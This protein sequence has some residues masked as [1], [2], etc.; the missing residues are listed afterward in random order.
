MFICASTECFPELGPKEVLQQ[1]VD[2]EFTAVELA[3]HEE[4]GWM[5]PSEVL[6]DFE[7]AVQT[8]GDTHRMHIAA[9][10]VDIH[11]TGDDYYKQF[12]AIC[13]L[14]KAIKVVTLVVPSSELGTPFN[15]EIERL[16][17]LVGIAAFEGAVVSMKTTI[18]CMT[19]DPDTA[20]VICDNVKGLALTLDPSHYI[21]GPHQGRSY[22]KL[23]KYVQHVHLRDTS[24]DSLQVRVGQGEI[25][26]G[27]LATMLTKQGYS[28]AL[29]VH[30]T[31]SEGVD[32]FGEMRKMRLLLDSLL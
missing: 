19:Q 26:Y 5:K 20:A 25:D 23:L 2:L 18:G 13:K 7:R 32:H 24:K 30:I 14:A 27:R 3:L 31:P 17:N 29:G 22:D 12:A 9:L 6:G 8:C 21:A 15:E 11:A 1:L 16:K 28:R 4:N 10:S